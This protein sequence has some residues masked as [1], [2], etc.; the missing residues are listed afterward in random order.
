[1]QIYEYTKGD[2]KV[3]TD[4]I[5]L[6]ILLIQ[7]FLANRS[8]WAKGIPLNIVEKSIE[9]SV[10]FGIYHVDKQIGFAR[11]ITDLATFGYLCDVFVLEEYRGKGASKFLMKCIMQVPDFQGF[12]RWQLATYDAHTLYEKFGFNP[13]ARPDRGMEILKTDIYESK[14]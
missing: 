1:M 10:C 6:D 7:D 2:F 8:Y 5:K 9:N 3:S 4:K 13:I 12:R 11:V 14:K